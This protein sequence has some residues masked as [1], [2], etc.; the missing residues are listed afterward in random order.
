MA[1]TLDTHA[2]VTE[3]TDAGLSASQAEAIVATVSR[4]D[5]E[6]ATRGDLESLE[7]RLEKSISAA[8]S[9]SERRTIL[10][11][12]AIAGLLFAALRVFGR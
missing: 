12:L 10:A 8:I 1:Y 4:S 5:S 9:A 6:L 2:A 7:N 3:L 11:V